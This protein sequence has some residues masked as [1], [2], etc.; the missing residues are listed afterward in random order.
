VVHFYRTPRVLTLIFNDLRWK[1]ST[2]TKEIFLTFDDGPI[3]GLTEYVVEQLHEYNAKATFFC[4]G[5][6]ICKYPQIFKMLIENGHGIGNHT[7]NHLKA[8][9]V[10]SSTYLENVIKCKNIINDTIGECEVSLFRPPYGQLTKKLIKDLKK[11]FEIV[12]W[13][14]LAYDFSRRHANQKSLQKTISSTGPGSIIVFHDNYKAEDKLKYM[15]PRF[16]GHFTDSG[17][18]FKKL[19]TI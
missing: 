3:P 4:V 2:E 17:Y 13:D 1:I 11:D 12:M 10:N 16:L 19:S 9:E 18:Q 15:L 6:N 7:Y 5:D 14:V 8:W